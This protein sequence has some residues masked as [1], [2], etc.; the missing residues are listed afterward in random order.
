MS[1]ADFYDV[2]A[3]KHCVC[4]CDNPHINHFKQKIVIAVEL[5]NPDQPRESS[6]WI[7]YLSTC[8]RCQEKVTMANGFGGINLVGIDAIRAA[9]E[10]AAKRDRA[11]LDW[12]QVEITKISGN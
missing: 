3:A 2:V 10:E 9:A 1:K 11:K 5:D 7:V 12:S 4:A 6:R 8:K